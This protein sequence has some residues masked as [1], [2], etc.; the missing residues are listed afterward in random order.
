MRKEHQPGVFARI[1]RFVD[2]LSITAVA[3]AMAKLEEMARDRR[4]KLLVERHRR[5]KGLIA[6]RRTEGRRISPKQK[7]VFD[8][9]LRELQEIET[10]RFPSYLC[11]V[12]W[13]AGVS[14]ERAL[15]IIRSRPDM[16]E[17]H[18]DVPKAFNLK[19]IRRSK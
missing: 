10:Q 18:P 8:A 3:D 1:R 17:A 11:F 15:R 13:E 12:G 4:R 9:S 7:A 14:V 2:E 19:T 6:S 5:I 16:F